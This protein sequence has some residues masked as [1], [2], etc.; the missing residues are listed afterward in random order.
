MSRS[1]R[2]TPICGNAGNSDKL[3]K[4]YANR[5]FRRREKQC[6]Q[7]ENWDKLPYVMDDVYNVWNM[8]KDG[9]SWFGWMKV[10]N[11]ILHVDIDNDI[12]L[13]RDTYK[14]LMRK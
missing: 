14:K 3:S 11:Y 6:I 10:E 7:T 1:H 12:D 13:W 2:K 9:K 5:A 8:C 4:R